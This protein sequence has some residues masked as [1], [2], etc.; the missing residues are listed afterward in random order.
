MSVST[1]APASRLSPPEAI[2]HEEDVA[3][4]L[5]EFTAV[6]RDF[7]VEL[8]NPG[9]ASCLGK[10]DYDPPLVGAFRA[11]RGHRIRARR[12]GA[13]SHRARESG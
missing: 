10:V 4:H 12:R 11:R 8:G 5:A 9:G 13:V 7:F 2:F 6:N 3:A 1:A